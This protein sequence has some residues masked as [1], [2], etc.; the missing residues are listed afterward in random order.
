MA[1]FGKLRA[2]LA[3]TRN[4]LL[5]Q[6]QSIFS[7]HAGLDD[8]TLE[9]LEELL[10]SADL[11][12]ETTENVI[13]RLRERAR[14]ERIE[15]SHRLQE[16]L[17]EELIRL[18]DGQVSWDPDAFFSPSQRPFVI[19]VV[20][21]NGSGKTTTIGKLAAQ[22]TA[23]GKKVLI[24]AADTFRAAA[25]EQLKIWAERS[26]SQ[27]VQQQPG[28][29]PAAVAFDAAR[30]A[31]ARGMDVLIVD[32]AGR[33]HTKVNLMEE[34]K[35]VHRVLGKQIPGAPHET[36]IVLDA[37]IGQNARRQVEEFSRAVGL[38]GII[39]TKLDGTAKGGVVLGIAGEYSVPV[40][41]I[42]V[43]ESIDDLEPFDAPAFVQALFENHGEK[44]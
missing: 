24:A 33:L 26:G 36:F 39:L 21:V 7:G 38:T 29:D 23:R 12:V 42:G 20:G 17:Q 40:R 6:L 28:A 30:A 1:W 27:L 35:K 44:R 32:T 2:G 15:D 25:A 14:E 10:I 19:M 11:G 3:K 37:T 13:E 5:G 43:G 41:F 22:F 4:S 16:I 9:E 18:L 31:L 34:L 8:E